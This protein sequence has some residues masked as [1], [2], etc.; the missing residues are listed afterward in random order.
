MTR[1]IYSRGYAQFLD[2]LVKE[3]HNMDLT[4]TEVAKRLGRP[5]S[6]VSKYE[7]GERRIDIAELIE[8]LTAYRSDPLDF[9]TRLIQQR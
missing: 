3:R 7:N 8:I 9:L 2:L 4:Q 6:F 1:S 5:Q